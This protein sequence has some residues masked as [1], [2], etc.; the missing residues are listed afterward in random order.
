MIML[1]TVFV[2]KKIVLRNEGG[3][4]GLIV[5]ITILYLNRNKTLPIRGGRQDF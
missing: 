1:S 2:D 5:F 3:G 4:E